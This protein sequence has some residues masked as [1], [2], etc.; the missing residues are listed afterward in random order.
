MAITSAIFG[1]YY[2]P[3]SAAD[4][5]HYNTLACRHVVG[6]VPE[7]HY[8]MLTLS[9]RECSACVREK[10]RYCAEPLWILA[11]RRGW[12]TPSDNVPFLR[13]Y[14]GFRI[15]QPIEITENWGSVSLTEAATDILK[16]T[17][18]NWNTAAFNCREPITVAF[19][20]RVCDILKLAR[21]KNRPCT[22]A[23]TC[24]QKSSKACDRAAIFPLNGHRP[25]PRIGPIRLLLQNDSKRC[26]GRP[27]GKGPRFHLWCSVC[28]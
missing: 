4:S 27:L 2:A 14:P 11:R 15:P 22:I 5:N 21:E 26:P 16:L 6:K 8:G 17:K 20:R 18:L 25:L 3:I 10:R 12:S 28:P 1:H 23:I 7:L 13:C 24:N 19:A 9:R